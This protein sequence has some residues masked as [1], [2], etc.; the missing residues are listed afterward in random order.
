MG[1]L[2]EAVTDGESGVLVRPDDPAALADAIACVATDDDV[3]AKLA[4]GARTRGCTLL[5]SGRRR[6]PRGD[7]PNGDGTPVKVAHLTTADVSLRLL[8]FAQLCAVRDAGGEAIGISAPG[9]FVAELERAG[10]RHIP[11]RSSTRSS[12]PIADM[13]AACELYGILR[14]ERVDVLHTH[15]PKPGLYGRVVGRLAHVPVIVNTVHGL[16]ATE[17]D[18]WMRRGLVYALEAVAA[19]FSDAELTQNPEDLALMER[20]HLTKHARLL[21]NGVD[22]ARFDIARFSSEER[23]A[24]RASIG[25]RDDTIVVGAAGRL[26]AEKGYPELFEAMAALDPTRYL[27]VAAGAEDPDKPDAL[28]PAV[29]EAARRRGVVFAGHRDDIEALY[30][31]MDL[32]VHPSHR[33]G[34]P[35]VSMEAAAMTLPVVTTDVRGCRQVVEHGR[36]GFIVPVRDACALAQAISTLGDDPGLRRHMGTA[37]RERAVVE[38][39]EQRVVERVLGTYVEVATRKRVTSVTITLGS[40]TASLG[41]IASQH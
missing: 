33:E 10:I 25:A 27:L 14:R 37:A 38:F 9:P 26:V 6:T 36:T 22:L 7:L 15:N 13:R 4:A 23:R 24:T 17:D 35:R 3:R 41:G 31:A 29:L 30:A 12:D 2:R 32:F 8:L 34:F 19:R 16:Y 40:R 5:V 28:S 11:L 18:A 1:G 21:G 39:D 20:L